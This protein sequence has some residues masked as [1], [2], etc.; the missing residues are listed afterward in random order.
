M[1]LKLFLTLT[2]NRIKS[3]FFLSFMM[4]ILC[5]IDLIGQVEYVVISGI[6]I[7]GNRKTSQNVI[8]MELDFKIG[9]T[10]F[11]SKLPYKI[12]IN[13]H[14]LLSIGLFTM[15]KIN[16]KNWD[17]ENST[18]E[19]DIK[20]NEN[21]YIYPYIIFEL[22]D[23]NFNVWRKEQNYSLDRVN[24]GLALSHINL[25]GNKD[26]LKLKVQGGFTKKYEISYDFPY[27]KNKWGASVNVLYS[28]NRE[29]AY[30]TENNKL[31][32]FKSSDERKL[33]FQHRASFGVHRRD[34]SKSFQ[35]LFLEFQSL[36]TDSIVQN[37]LN[38]NYFLNNHHHLKSF[39]LEYEYIFNN[40]VYPLY[41]IGGHKIEFKI[42]KEG[43]GIFNNVNTTWFSVGA[44]K[45]S[46][47]TDR[48]FLSNRIK[49]KINLQE[50]QIPYYLNNAIGYK[51]DKI[52]GYQLYVLDG[53]DFVLFKTALKYSL[54]DRD[55]KLWDSF[56]KQLKVMNTKVFARANFDYGYARDPFYGLNNPLSNTNQYGYG[57]ALDMILYNNFTL[58][59]ELGI[60]KFGEKGVFFE[61]GF[62]F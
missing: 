20:L 43:L 42:R 40:N 14:R 5:S 29:M 31:L 15:A 56:P 11:L 52:T 26:K 61:S 62:N 36:V 35:R 34:N 50:N 19:I 51:N 8:L 60:T 24:Y 22:A 4:S 30:K 39:I 10:I 46:K 28:E 57:F 48:L 53:K 47:L 45:H 23:R 6:N 1:E 38:S 21:W 59:C 55:F 33:F 7:E 27:L 3:I 12:A 58:S 25:S 18:S 54:I 37:E 16:L 2:K 17:T 49:I 32:F 9:D 13:E 44:E 41:P